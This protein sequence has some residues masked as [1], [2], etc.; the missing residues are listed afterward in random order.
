[1]QVFTLKRRSVPDIHEG[2]RLLFSWVERLKDPKEALGAKVLL[3]TLDIERFI[4]ASSGLMRAYF[5]SRDQDLELGGLGVAHRLLGQRAIL[6]SDQF[7]MGGMSFD[8]HGAKAPEWQ[9]FGQELF[10]L[11]LLQVVKRQHSIAMVVNYCPS[12]DITFDA[13]RDHA[14]SVLKTQSEPC[15]LQNLS[16]SWAKSIQ[17]PNFD[18]YAKTIERAKNIF[19]SRPECRKVVL[20]RRNT[21]VFADTLDPVKLFFFAH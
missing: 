20:G 2:A 18:R 15:N 16:I 14:L 7:Y 8:S 5:R 13:W 6:S 10:F 12:S 17:E 11:P 3:D 9:G 4:S 21:H 1:M 19:K